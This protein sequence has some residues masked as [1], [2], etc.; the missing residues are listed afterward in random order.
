MKQLRE[1]IRKELKE[2]KEAIVKRPLPNDAKEILF[3]HLNLRPNHINGIQAIKSIRPSY[4]IYLN[5]D[6]SFTI[7]DLGDGFGF[8]LVNISG[9][10]YDVLDREQ[11]QLALIALNDLQIKAII[12]PSGGEE[13]EGGEEGDIEDIGAAPEEEGEEE[14]GEEEA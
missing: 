11:Q 12:N 2:L 13:G 14:G 5:N 1:Y 4:R 6:Q 7:N 3:N 10:D 8:G 9:K